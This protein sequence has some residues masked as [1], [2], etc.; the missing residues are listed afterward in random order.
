MATFEFEA[1]EPA[2]AVASTCS[3]GM[4]STNVE[5]LE[6]SKA[7]VFAEVNATSNAEQDIAESHQEEEIV[8]DEEKYKR[9]YLTLKRRCEQIENGNGK[10]VN[11]LYYVKKAIRRFKRERRLLKTK[12]DEYGDNYHSIPLTE[13]LEDAPDMNSVGLPPSYSSTVAPPK[14]MMGINSD[15]PFNQSGLPQ[16]QMPQ[17]R[18]SQQQFTQLFMSPGGSGKKKRHGK[19]E[20][21]KDPN[22]PKKPANAFFMFCQQERPKLQGESNRDAKDDFSHLDMT[23]ELAKMW[24]DL[25]T[26][27]KKRYYTMYEKDKERYEKE[28]KCYNKKESSKASMKSTQDGESHVKKVKREHEEKVIK[29][30]YVEGTPRDGQIPNQPE[31]K[32]RFNLFQLP[33]PLTIPPFT[34]VPG[35]TPGFLNLAQHHQALQRKSQNFPTSNVLGLTKD[36]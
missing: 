30:E 33:M 25:S 22:A 4:M 29:T 8:P 11:R 10:L 1:P 20:R 35:S 15:L 2:G 17:P 27:E 32:E 19:S 18:A 23:K 5:D 36:A 13:T 9:K 7:D 12:L 16:M 21:E 26:E 3:S 34:H 31:K 28:M 14:G 24:S 6:S